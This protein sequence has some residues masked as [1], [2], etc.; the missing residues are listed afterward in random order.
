MKKSSNYLTE[1]YQKLAPEDFL[2]ASKTEEKKRLSTKDSVV[3]LDETVEVEPPK[4]SE[5]AVTD[6]PAAGIKILD[7]FSLEKEV[8]PLKMIQPT[9]TQKVSTKKSNSPL[10]VSSVSPKLSV[11]SVRVSPKTPAEP[12]RVVSPLVKSLVS[13]EPAKVSSPATQ[14]EKPY[15]AGPRSRTKPHVAPVRQPSS[16]T[17]LTKPAHVE[18]QHS[19]P[20]ETQHSIPAETLP[21]LPAETQ[22]SVPVDTQASVPEDTQAS[23]P[24]ETQ[25]SLPEETQ[26][27]YRPGPK[28]RKKFLVVKEGE[29]EKASVQ[30]V[31]PKRKTEDLSTTVSPN[32]KRRV[33]TAVTP[34]AVQQADESI[35]DIEKFLAETDTIMEVSPAPPNQAALDRRRAKRPFQCPVCHGFFRSP[36]VLKQHLAKIHFWQR[37]LQ[38]PRETP[39][40]QGPFWLCSESPCHYAQ[41]TKESVASH[42]A[43]DHQVVFN[44]AKTLF[45]QFELPKMLVTIDDEVVVEAVQN[46]NN[47]LSKLKTSHT[48]T[49][50]CSVISL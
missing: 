45:P 33:D 37:L 25:A 34:E 24:G 22:A 21:S 8:T 5:E 15:K 50:Q 12:V 14:P 6:S 7:T 13:S 43:T 23:V 32:K 36:V 31:S 26:P 11:E 30:T 4:I 27:R 46:N 18:T 41:R 35:E 39:S 28:S 2:A 3:T 9:V 48:L 47:N 29:P 42:L 20:A 19:V 49:Q 40:L 1:F 17:P 38:F 44:I 16:S 10:S